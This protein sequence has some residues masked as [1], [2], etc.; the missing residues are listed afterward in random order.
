MLDGQAEVIVH[1]LILKPI[2]LIDDQSLCLK[3]ISLDGTGYQDK[4][5]TTVKSVENL[6]KLLYTVKAEMT[7]LSQQL[8]VW[9]ILIQ[10]DY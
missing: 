4:K 6:E 9:K 3:R 7:S 5:I 1:V 8:W 10:T 2:W